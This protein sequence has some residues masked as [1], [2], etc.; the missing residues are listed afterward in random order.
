VRDELS[1]IF[2]YLEAVTD[3]LPE[4]AEVGEPVLNNWHG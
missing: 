3:I 2:D 4:A 1:L